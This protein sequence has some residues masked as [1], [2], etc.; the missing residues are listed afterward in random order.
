MW[1]MRVFGLLVG[2][3]ARDIKVFVIRKWDFLV[4]RTPRSSAAPEG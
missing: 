2:L 1:R 3:I 4:G